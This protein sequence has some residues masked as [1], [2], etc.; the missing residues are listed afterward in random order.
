MNALS[1]WMIL[2]TLLASSAAT[3]STRAQNAA[4]QPVFPTEILANSTL[5]AEI[6]IPD[7]QA[8]YYRAQRFDWSGQM[9]RVT[10]NGH[11][12]FGPWK[13]GP[14]DPLAPDGGI[15]TAEEFGI[16]SPPGYAQAKPGETFLKIGVG[17]LQRV[18]SHEYNFN[19]RY[20]ITTPGQW[21]IRR[22]EGW[23]EFH[24]QFTTPHGWGYNYVKRVS[25]AANQPE[26]LI[27]HHLTNTGTKRIDTDQYCH[28]FISIDGRPADSAY[29]VQLPFEATALEPNS[30]R[31]KAIVQGHQITLLTAADDN[32]GLR[33]PL[34]GLT[35]VARDYDFL[36]ANHLTGASLRVTGDTA[37]S[38]MV[39][40]A[41]VNAVCIEPFIKIQLAPGKIIAW[42]TRYRFDTP[43]PAI[44]K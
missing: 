35:G 39:F 11:T 38:Q 3:I 14:H 25:I 42:T 17:E 16:T 1:S 8:G 28:N 24:Q 27:E 2:M 20:P 10:C 13:K 23:I 41:C 31:A 6:L 40:Y 33:A 22:G 18:D 29:T 7:G 37:P 26:I 44:Q 30:L 21:T 43:S 9:A 5:R 34:S 36:V 12:F 19:K 4:T 32:P 15:G